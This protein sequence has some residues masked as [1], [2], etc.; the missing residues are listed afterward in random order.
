[1]IG[2]GCGE[3][4]GFGAGVRYT[5]ADGNSDVNDRQS[6]CGNGYDVRGWGCGCG[7]GTSY[8]GGRGSGHW[9]DERHKVAEVVA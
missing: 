2:S 9:G 4:D 7:Y 5:G 3:I 6:G 1:M 8:G